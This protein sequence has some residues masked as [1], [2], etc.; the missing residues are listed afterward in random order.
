MKTR[1]C[2]T[3]VLFTFGDPGHPGTCRLRIFLL[4]PDKPAVVVL[5][6]LPGPGA[7]VSD[8]IE[9]IAS[10][11]RIEL[12]PFNVGVATI[13]PGFYD[14]GFNET[15]AESYQQWSHERDVHIPMP[16]AGLVLKAQKDPQPMIDAMIEAIPDQK[17]A[18]RTMLPE[19]AIVETKLAQ[20][21]GWK[22]KAS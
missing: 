22:T 15:G 8:A 21:L 18:Y 3:D 6:E 16:P 5:T 17:S 7:C 12:A 20:E 10:T 1:S 4:G 14:T 2:Q 13:N 19:E 11:M 9:G